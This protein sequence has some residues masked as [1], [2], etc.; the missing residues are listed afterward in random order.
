MW[1]CRK[2]GVGD[3]LCFMCK[4]E[5]GMDDVYVEMSLEDINKI[6]FCKFGPFVDVYRYLDLGHKDNEMGIILMG[7]TRVHFLAKQEPE[8]ELN[9]IDS[10]YMKM[11]KERAQ[12][13]INLLEKI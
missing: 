10:I 3:G 9:P 12:G 8:Q 5:M 4:R 6:R 11:V 2:C 13:L 1:A 7:N